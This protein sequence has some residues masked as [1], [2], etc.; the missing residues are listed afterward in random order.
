[1]GHVIDVDPSRVDQLAQLL[2]GVARDLAVVAQGAATAWRRAAAAGGGAELKAVAAEAAVRWGG[3]LV[4]TSELTEQLGAATAGAAQAY[5]E[6]EERVR[7]S[8]V[9]GRE[10]IGR[11]G[12]VLP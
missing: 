4:A 6:V 2:D 1:M 8:W 10:M 5:R 7:L 9:A 3:D 12:K 11:D